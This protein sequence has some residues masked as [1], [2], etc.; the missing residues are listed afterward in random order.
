MIEIEN[1]DSLSPAVI[2]KQQI[3]VWGYFIIKLWALSQISYANLQQVVLDTGLN[4]DLE[5]IVLN[6]SLEVSTYE[7]MLQISTLL[8]SYFVFCSI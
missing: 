3:S 2:A 6:F 1:K 7:L 5:T 8:T 4:P